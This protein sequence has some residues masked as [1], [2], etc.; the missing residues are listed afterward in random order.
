MTPGKWCNATLSDAILC[1]RFQGPGM[2]ELLR[3]GA[4]AY[5]T[6][7]KAFSL[8]GQIQGIAGAGLRGRLGQVIRLR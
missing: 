4:R 1:D 3:L 7:D 8:G 6:G 2:S 5:A